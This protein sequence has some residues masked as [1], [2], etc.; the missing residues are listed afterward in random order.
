[1][2][3]EKTMLRMSVIVN[4]YNMHREAQR[5]LFSLT[6]GYQQK[7]ANTDY[8]VIA[9]ENGSSEPLGERTVEAFGENFRYVYYDSK[10][11]SPCAALNHSVE[12]AKADVVMLCID[13]A[14]ILSPGILN[15]TLLAIELFD[16]PFIYTLGMHIGKKPQN[17]LVEEGYNRDVEDKLLA[18]VDWHADGYKLFG[19]SSV[20]QS[21]KNG[22]FSQLQESSCF[23]M[24]RDD[25]LALRGFDE[26]FDSA[27]GG[28]ANLDIFSRV[29][30]DSKYTPIMLLGEA[31]F[32]Q[33]HGGVAT[34][35][36]MELHP[37]EQML[38]EYD[39]IKGRAYEPIYRKPIYFG[40]LD[41]SAHSKL[42]SFD[43]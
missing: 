22:F 16:H 31:S 5:T 21:S 8:E 20:A 34:N 39:L 29:H 14:R 32:H 30:E 41:K 23:A 38:K 9:V 3:K 7:V 13:G 17:F 40:R 26:R 4:F 11:P 36:K 37:W 28:I 18:G 27:G 15:Y 12:N 25:Y 19:I 35:V 10:T 2:Q 43:G 6:S 33:F 42:L 1:M 24:K